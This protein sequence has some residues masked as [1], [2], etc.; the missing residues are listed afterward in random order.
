[1]NYLLLINLTSLNVRFI[2]K[3]AEL[4]LITY[5]DRIFLAQC[6][7]RSRESWE[8]SDT[9]PQ[10]KKK[11]RILFR[12]KKPRPDKKKKIPEKKFKPQYPCANKH[13][14][15]YKHNYVHIYNSGID[16][17]AN[18]QTGNRLKSNHWKSKSLKVSKCKIP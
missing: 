4:T 7:T 1:M 11:I 13:Y 9:P 12:N 16:L 3:T 14:K 5:A 15:H 8:I 6:S 17:K 18:I 2:P 10:E